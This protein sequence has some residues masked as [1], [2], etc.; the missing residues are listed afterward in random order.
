M[1]PLARIGSPIEDPQSR[2][3]SVFESHVC[4]ILMERKNNCSMRE[5]KAREAG[6]CSFTYLLLADML[7]LPDMLVEVDN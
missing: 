6:D 7:A 5:S 4:G 3:Q 2:L 1:L